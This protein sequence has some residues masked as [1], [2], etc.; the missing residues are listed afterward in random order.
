MADLTS[1]DRVLQKKD[2][3]DTGFGEEEDMVNEEEEE[4]YYHGT[5]LQ[6]DDTSTHGLEGEFGR[7]PTHVETSPNVGENH[8]KQ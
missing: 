6:Y 2:E 8:K 4:T 1:K 7:T 3:Q 5:Q